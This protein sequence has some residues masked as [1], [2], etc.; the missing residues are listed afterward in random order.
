MDPQPPVKPRIEQETIT[1][2][3]EKITVG[4]KISY[5]GSEYEVVELPSET[6]GHK[7]V[8]RGKT[9][10]P[11]ITVE[12]LRNALESGN[13]TLIL[14]TKKEVPPSEE[15]AKLTQAFEEAKKYAMMHL[16]TLRRR[17]GSAMASIELNVRLQ[18]FFKG[19]SPESLSSTLGRELRSQ[20]RDLE[21]QYMQAITE[22]EERPD[23][24]ITVE[25]REVSMYEAV[26]NSARRAFNSREGNRINLQNGEFSPKFTE[27]WHRAYRGGPRLGVFIGRIIKRAEKD[28]MAEIATQP[29][30]SQAPSPAPE[31]ESI[32]PVKEARADASERKRDW[33]IIKKLGKIE[34]GG[35]ISY[36]ER[37]Y[38]VKEI[39]TSKNNGEYILAPWL[40]PDAPTFNL[41]FSEMVRWLK[42]GAIVEP[43]ETPRTDIEFEQP[44]AQPEVA[45]VIEPT[46]SPKVEEWTERD[47]ERL[48]E[49]ERKLAQIDD[50]ERRRQEELENPEVTVEEYISATPRLTEFG[51]KHSRENWDTEREL[52]AKVDAVRAF[53]YFM[54]EINLD[55]WEK[56]EKTLWR[57]VFDR[58]NAKYDTML[59]ELEK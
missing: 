48:A 50:I 59:A 13:A 6:N 41:T 7:Y 28:F 3:L 23:A 24:P 1:K 38:K 56:K 57:A 29:S 9:I 16:E 53:K 21:T 40:E 20:I 8:L 34:V 33:E 52:H 30:P 2:Q 36:Q 22:S 18:D 46:P 15:V 51:K 10:N 54:G 39:P 31:P 25:G 26:V 19:I 32:P 45:P 5:Q 11:K 47:A 37:T 12:Q 4:S 44:V 35:K 58:I 27:D 17:G 14:P 49:I 55:E 42:D 43:E